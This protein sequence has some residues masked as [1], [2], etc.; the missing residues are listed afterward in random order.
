MNIR[1]MI[2]Q[3]NFIWYRVSELPNNEKSLNWIRY[4]RNK[5]QIHDNAILSLAYTLQ[6]MKIE[7]L[8]IK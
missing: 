1:D 3:L 4:I 8:W 7:A 6:S 2:K 5:L